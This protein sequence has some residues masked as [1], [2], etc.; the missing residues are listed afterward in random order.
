M[1]AAHISC[2]V[3]R[4]A[5]IVVAGDPARAM[6]VT[7]ELFPDAEITLVTM[8]ELKNATPISVLRRL[9]RIGAK[10]L[11]LCYENIEVLDERPFHELAARAMGA[12]ELVVVDPSGRSRHRPLS[13]MPLRIVL[14]ITTD[15]V[16]GSIL[17][18]AVNTVLPLLGR[19]RS[20]TPAFHQEG[21]DKQNAFDLA[22]LRSLGQSTATNIGGSA[23]HSVGIVRA[24]GDLGYNIR[25]ISRPPVPEFGH[26]K[27]KVT[28]VP[29]RPTT[30]KV[31]PLSD[32][33]NHLR[34]LWQSWR[35]LASDPPRAVY[36]RHT[37]FDPS[38]SILALLLGRP[39]ILEHEGSEELMAASGD[40][41]PCLRTLRACERLNHRVASVVV[42]VSEEVRADLARRRGVPGEKIIVCPSGVD[43]SRFSPRSG[44]QQRREELGISPET[45]IVGFSGTF[46]PW[47]GTETL[48]EAILRLPAEADLCFLFIGDG[49]GRTRIQVQLAEARHMCVFVG[50]VSLSEMPSYLDAC[51]VLVCPTTPMPGSTEFFGSPTKLFEYMAVEKPIIASNIGQVATVI[52]HE[53]NGFLIPTRDPTALA[54]AIL[55]LLH[56]DELRM[57]L[58][59]AAREDVVRKYNWNRNAKAIREQILVSSHRTSESLRNLRNRQE[60]SVRP[61]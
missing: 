48:A 23:S 32:L 60:T 24:F 19:H 25:V 13:T 22:Y 2:E 45:T 53:E 17:L 35:L 37:R 47:H 11:V 46:E 29:Y 61:E 20:R 34:F 58:G 31:H 52:R 28:T 30:L 51:D 8:V 41:T 49:A 26:R 5:L 21:D 43:S 10:I 12:S 4:V 57:R 18:A 44:G 38:G 33:E 59:R 3:T 9:R 7:E 39:L 56:D 36:Q 27:V 6:K 15:A 42:A 1:A 40:P 55:R 14:R 54:E 50:L 16:F